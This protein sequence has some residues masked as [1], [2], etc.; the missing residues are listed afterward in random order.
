MQT[1][2]LT[3]RFKLITTV[4]FL[5]LAIL[6]FGIF[7]FLSKQSSCL[8]IY[9]LAL[10]IFGI[11]RGFRTLNEEYIVVGEKAIEHHR[12]GSTFEIKW[13]DVENISP[14]W[15]VLGKQDSL[16]VDK[17]KVKIQDMSTFGAWHVINIL[18]PQEAFVPLSCFSEN[19]RDSDLG[20]QIKQHAPHLF[21]KEKSAQSA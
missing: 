18:K 6:Q 14:R 7:I 3:P 20:Q 2:Y 21:E 9:I 19:W 15:F 12:R 1:Y 17:S 11:F 4:V 13:S 10:S 16:I 8:V 5:P